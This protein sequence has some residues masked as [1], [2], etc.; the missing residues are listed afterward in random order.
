LQD[1]YLGFCNQALWPLLHCFQERARI[2]IRQ[3][4]AYRQVQARFAASLLPLLREGDLVWVHDYHLLLLGR[5]LRARGWTGRIGF[6]LHTPF[7]PYELW[8]VLPDARGTLEAL[9]D[10]DVM[11]FHVP[12]SLDNYV[13]CCRRE[14]GAKMHGAA[15]AAAGRRQHVDVYP[16]GIDPSEF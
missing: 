13:Y 2:H 15:L 11:G 1:Y 9:L 6:F 10:Y 14:L 4:A 16:V 3:E 5:D 12:G 8:Q 7:P